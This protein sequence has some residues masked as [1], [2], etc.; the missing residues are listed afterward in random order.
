L[1]FSR[2]DFEKALQQHSYEFS[3]GQLVRGKAF[4]YESDGALIDI[5]G[6]SSAF[7]PL[8]EASLSRTQPLTEV[9]PLGE[10]REFVIIR[11]QNA[12]GQVT[13]SLRQLALNQLW[14][15]L[16]A[17]QDT[18]ETVRVR[19]SGT[20]R[21]GV[22]VDVDGLRGFIPRSH[23]IERENLD[24]LV[25]KALTVTLLEVNPKAKKLVLSQRLASQAASL[26]QIA[27][28]QLVDGKISSIRP[29]GVFVEF[30]GTSG[31]LHIKQISKNYVSSL[32]AVFQ[33]GQSIRAVVID[34]D[35][36]KRRVSL[37]TQVLETYPGEMLENMAAVMAEAETRAQKLSISPS[38]PPE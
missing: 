33:V 30:G 28:G 1:S 27:V 22:T 29:F 7:L 12:E 36:V 11:E 23:L 4:S 16:V 38:T 8:Q 34:L 5:G 3:Q 24:A 26:S 18:D 15:R 19:V 31:L 32:D 14:D 13:L 25:G 2:D 9:V 37:S 35:D 10:E 21:G 20:N 6:K 17:M